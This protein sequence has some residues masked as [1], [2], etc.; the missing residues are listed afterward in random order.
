MGQFSSLASKLNGFFLQSN[1]L[2]VSDANRSKNFHQL[3]RLNCPTCSFCSVVSANR[4]PGLEYYIILHLSFECLLTKATF[5]TDQ[6]RR[7][8]DS[9]RVCTCYNWRKQHSVAETG[10]TGFTYMTQTALQLLNPEKDASNPFSAFP[11]LNM[12][13]GYLCKKTIKYWEEKRQIP[14]IG[15]NTKNKER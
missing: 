13:Y 8:P 11:N 6:S 12:Q 5:L 4:N 10:R 1:W 9:S 3:K 2:F 15:C 7:W 14:L